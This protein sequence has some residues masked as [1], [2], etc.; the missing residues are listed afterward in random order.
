MELLSF[1]TKGLDQ[2]LDL[3]CDLHNI[4]R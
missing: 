4:G 1:S 3:K 2:L